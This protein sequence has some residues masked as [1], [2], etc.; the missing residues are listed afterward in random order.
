VAKWN[1]VEGE[2]G[3]S[4]NLLDSFEEE[5]DY[6]DESYAENQAASKEFPGVLSDIEVIATEIALDRRLLAMILALSKRPRYAEE[7]VSLRIYGKR[8]VKVRK[9]VREPYR[10]R[11]GY[12]EYRVVEK[13]VVEEREDYYTMPP[14][15]AYRALKRLRGLGLV[16]THRGVDFRKRYYKLTKLGQKVAE[17]VAALV[18]GKLKSAAKRHGG[19]YLLTEGDLERE[20]RS[21]GVEPTLLVEALGLEQVEVDYRDYYA[22]PE[23]RPW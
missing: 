13:E 3:E 19:R 2:L 18:R 11:F 22:L 12:T 4:G 8:R 21:M 6:L 1:P 14:S 16:E 17:K 9:K 15:T 10:D 5:E 23:K 7:L 20:A